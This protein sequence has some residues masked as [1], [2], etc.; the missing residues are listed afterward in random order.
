MFAAHGF[1]TYTLDYVPHIRGHLNNINKSRRIFIKFAQNQRRASPV[2][3]EE[4]RFAL[5]LEFSVNVEILS[6][7][8]ERDEDFAAL[9]SPRHESLAVV[10]VDVDGLRSAGA[11]GGGGGRGGRG[12]GGRGVGASSITSALRGTG[13]ASIHVGQTDDER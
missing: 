11:L 8:I 13:G 3:P 10:D 2:R 6:D 4:A 7:E 1:E 12:R 5:V 9:L